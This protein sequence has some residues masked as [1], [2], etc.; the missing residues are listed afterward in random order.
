M[1]ADPPAVTFENAL[2]VVAGFGQAQGGVPAPEALAED[3]FD[4]LVYDWKLSDLPAALRDAKGLLRVGASVKFTVDSAEGVLVFTAKGS[5]RWSF[6][7][8]PQPGLLLPELAELGP[9][10]DWT[11]DEL[12]SGDWESAADAIADADARAEFTKSQWTSEI[13]NDTNRSVWIGPDQ[14][15]FATWLAETVPKG[16][17]NKLFSRPGALVLLA[18]W[19]GGRSVAAGDSLAVG[20]LSERPGAEAKDQELLGPRLAERREGE[21]LQLWRL[22]RVDTHSDL[23]DE[24]R[25]PLNRAVGLTAAMLIAAEEDGMLRPAS[26]RPEAWALPRAP[27]RGGSDVDAIV[28][29][30]RWVGEDLSEIRFAIAGDIAA[31]MIH[32]PLDGGP[33][34]PPRDA[35]RI[36]YHRAVHANV[37]ESLERQQKLEESFRALDDQ[38]AAMR[39]STDETVDG[40][41][42]K[43]LAGAL[44]I[45][46]AALTSSEVRNWPATIAGLI[47]AGYL[48]LSAL[49]LASWRRNDADVRLAEAG[50]YAAQ[51]VEGLGGQLEESTR[52]WRARLQRRV[53]FATGL[54]WALATLLAIG[55]LIANSSVRAW[56]G[57]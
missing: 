30:A 49:T 42:A 37:V 4:V 7:A 5:D 34:A 35:A 54:L 15:G 9:R 43:S 57:F 14:A 51:R 24:L 1:S 23:P 11:T 50:A 19:A 56:L 8:G 39:A 12:L 16:I 32:D 33:A 53:R 3:N 44:A 38:A 47:L 46:I 6:G 17:A 10:A 29:L 40:T 52:K 27:G 36:A 13:A 55:A 48:A 18:D 26:D 31:R 22:L 41:V 28:E 20:S 21:R 25:R 45:A 2:K